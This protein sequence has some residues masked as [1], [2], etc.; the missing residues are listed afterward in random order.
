M[1]K[2]YTITLNLYA[3][4]I[5]GAICGGVFLFYQLGWD[6]KAKIPDIYIFAASMLTVFIG[7][8]GFLYT[9]Y[10]R[11]EQTLLKQQEFSLYLIQKWNEPDFSML[12]AD[13][14]A[15][16]AKTDKEEDPAEK[17]AIIRNSPGGQRAVVSMLN[18][19]EYVHIAI[20]CGVADEN[21]LHSFF[22]AIV[23]WCWHHTDTWIDHLRRQEK[24]DRLY[25]EFQLLHE[26][27]AAN[28]PQPSQI[29]TGTKTK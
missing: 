5:A 1:W 25:R 23:V 29:V 3:I 9:L 10:Q 18:H 26:R 21:V 8:G 16:L 6:A 27:W 15:V 7:L 4:I 24:N 22:R 12:V 19:L 14:S 28:A 20:A 17:R 2:R 13:A 11:E